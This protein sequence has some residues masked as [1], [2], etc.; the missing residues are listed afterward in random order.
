MG[1][2][3]LDDLN[4]LVAD[5]LHRSTEATGELAGLLVRTGGNPFFV[6][7]FLRELHAR[8][9][10]RLDSTRRRWQWDLAQIQ[11]VGMTD[12]VVDLMVGKI[13]RLSPTTQQALQ[14]AACLGNRFALTVLA[15]I[16]GKSARDTGSNLWEAIQKVGGDRPNRI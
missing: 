15:T 7:Q 9:L 11:A 16:Y 2:L 10:F 12:N 13:S 8:G 14:L 4:R 5:T 6:T 1:P 3:T